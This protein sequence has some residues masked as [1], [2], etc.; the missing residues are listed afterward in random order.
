M[1]WGRFGIMWP[2]NGWRNCPPTAVEVAAFAS[3]EH[4]YCLSDV[5]GLQR[6]ASLLNY[7]ETTVATIR[8][9]LGSAAWSG[10]HGKHVLLLFA[11]PDDYFTYI[12]YHDTK[13]PTF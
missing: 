10:Y 4:F 13:A 6:T 1:N 3:S 7:A 5:G 12:S 11:D 9:F 2:A 8:S